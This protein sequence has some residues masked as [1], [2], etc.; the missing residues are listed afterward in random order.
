M[1]LF[2]V[3]RSAAITVG[4]TTNNDAQASYSNWRAASIS[5]HREAAST[6]RWNTDDYA[7]GTANGTSMATP[8]VAGAAALYLQANPGAS[9]AEVANAIVGNATSGALN[10][11]GSDRATDSCA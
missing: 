10:A 1:Q 8:H 7:M 2:A 11:L 9:P 5:M 3:E 6:R 4:A